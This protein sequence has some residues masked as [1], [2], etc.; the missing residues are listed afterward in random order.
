MKHM[1]QSKLFRKYDEIH[2]I[3]YIIYIDIQRCIGLTCSYTPQ[4]PLGRT[5]AHGHGARCTGG[6][7]GM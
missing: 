5:A 7:R 3:H 2:Y 6:T 4:F 1:L